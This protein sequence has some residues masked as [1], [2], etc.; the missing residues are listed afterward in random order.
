MIMGVTMIVLNSDSVLYEMSK[1]TQ[2]HKPSR[3][4]VFVFLLVKLCLLIKI[5]Q[6]S[7]VSRIAL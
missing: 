2:V 4:L 7:Q 5:S 6:G 3:G 1:V